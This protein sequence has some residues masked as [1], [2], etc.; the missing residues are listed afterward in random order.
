MTQEKA[1]LLRLNGIAIGMVWAHEVV[2]QENFLW[3]KID[4]L[5]FCSLWQSP[6]Q[7]FTAEERK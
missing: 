1:Y 3:F 4:G 7:K 6:D 2:E 5:A